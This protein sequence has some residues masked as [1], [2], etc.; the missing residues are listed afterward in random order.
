MGINVQK[1]VPEDAY[2]ITKVLYEAW[3]D[4]YPNKE[5]KI[6]VDDVEYKFKDSFNKENL[7]NRASKIKNYSNKEEMLIAKEN[8][9]V[10]GLVKIKKEEKKNEIEAIYVLPEN[11]RKGVGAMLWDEAQKYFDEDFDNVVNV[12]VY[13][14]KAINFYKKIG[15]QETVVV[16]NDEKFKMKSGSII[17]QTRLA[18]KNN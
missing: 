4:T 16:W 8:G 2:E 7:E 11:Q 10:V 6:T 13:N 1:A 3:L 5:Y 18:I 9:K 14:K 15:F 12:A 17:P